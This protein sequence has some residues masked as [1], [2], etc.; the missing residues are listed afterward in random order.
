MMTQGRNLSIPRLTF[1][2]SVFVNTFGHTCVY[3][4]VGEILV[5]QVCYV[6]NLLQTEYKLYN[7][8]IKI[9]QFN[10]RSI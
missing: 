10:T 3:C 8:L 5:A 2:M 7:I 4:A 9:V 6:L 1:I